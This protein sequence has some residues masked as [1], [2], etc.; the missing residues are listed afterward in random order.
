MKNKSKPLKEGKMKGN[1]KAY[2]EEGR[3]AGPPPKPTV[4]NKANKG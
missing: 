2:T 4:K 1:L 3:Q